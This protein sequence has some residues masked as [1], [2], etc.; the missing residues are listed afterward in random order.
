[1]GK[2][3]KFAD[4]LEPLIKNHLANGGQL[5]SGNFF[6]TK[7]LC[8]PISLLL[9]TI[10]RL[11]TDLNSCE[12]LLNKAYGLSSKEIWSFIV[13]FDGLE[14]TNYDDSDAYYCGLYIRNRYLKLL[15]YRPK[16]E[17]EKK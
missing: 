11:T 5:I 6:L 3:D 2:L 15:V 12:F 10:P 13:G 8:C 1:M 7:N 14:K 4:E 16:A 9:P 17:G